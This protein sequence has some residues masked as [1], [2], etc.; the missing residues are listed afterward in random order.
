MTPTIVDRGSAGTTPGLSRG[1][2][3]PDRWID[4]VGVGNIRGA[5]PE[6]P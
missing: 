1:E 2:H 3:P 4:P 5:V 6:G